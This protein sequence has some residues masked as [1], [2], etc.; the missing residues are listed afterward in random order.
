[1]NAKEIFEN[2]DTR[3]KDNPDNPRTFN[4]RLDLL[5]QHL[6]GYQTWLQGRGF[7]FTKNSN[8]WDDSFMSDLQDL[9]NNFD[10]YSKDTNFI[11]SRLR[12]LGAGDAYTTAFTS[13][14]W[15]LSQ[16]D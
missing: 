7:D 10:T 2:Y 6:T 16:S 15:D 12:K 3:D 5:K 14:K 4:Q 8:D 11:T 1:L 13:D 9:V